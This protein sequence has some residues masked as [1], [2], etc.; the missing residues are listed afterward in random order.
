MKKRG[1]ERETKHRRKFEI[2]AHNNEP[3]EEG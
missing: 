3:G 1:S 2:L